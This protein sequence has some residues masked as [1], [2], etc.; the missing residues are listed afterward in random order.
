MIEE[1]ELWED[2]ACSGA[3]QD[4]ITGPQWG[5]GFPPPHPERKGVSRLHVSF[6]VTCLVPVVFNSTSFCKIAGKCV[7]PSVV[8]F[9]GGGF[10][11][12]DHFKNLFTRFSKFIENN[13]HAVTYD[14]LVKIL[15][16]FL[17]LW[18]YI[19]LIK[20]GKVLAA[21]SS[22]FLFDPIISVSHSFSSWDSG[23]TR[24][25]PLNPV[26]QVTKH[27]PFPLASLRAVAGGGSASLLQ[28]SQIFCLSC[29]E[30]HRVNF[31]F[32]K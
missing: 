9:G 28:S 11:S 8:F 17:D 26:S 10:L 20:I 22:D 12:S 25:R 3:Y 13:H 21:I 16:I 32:Q 30:A 23:Y 31:W 7:I 27:G 29:C 6:P 18:V 2:A 24:V 4:S 5:I 1:K 19:F 14:A 15:L